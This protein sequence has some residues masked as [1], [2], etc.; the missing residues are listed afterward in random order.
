MANWETV[1]VDTDQMEPGKF[2][3]IQTNKDNATALIPVENK[4]LKIDFINSRYLEI[5]SAVNNP[6]IQIYEM[7][8]EGVYKQTDADIKVKPGTK[9]IVEMN[10]PITGYL[11]IK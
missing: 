9:I 5:Q 4:E 8:A 1:M 10:K 6:I 7:L 2:Y 3:E 11:I